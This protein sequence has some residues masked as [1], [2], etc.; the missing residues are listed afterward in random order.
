MKTPAQ[1]VLAELEHELRP[2]ARLLQF[3]AEGRLAIVEMMLRSATIREI[4]AAAVKRG[5]KLSVGTV[6]NLSIR[7]GR[8]RRLYEEHAAMRER[9]LD[10]LQAAGFAAEAVQAVA[11]RALP[12]LTE[13]SAA[14]LGELVFDKITSGKKVD[15]GELQPLVDLF[16]DLLDRA[17]KD[18]EFGLKVQEAQLDREK[19]EL[20]KRKAE[21]AE[22]TEGALKDASLTPEERARRIAEIY[23]RA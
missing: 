22:Q 21:Q 18:K 4:Q 12:Q 6:S 11:T 14:A 3:D 20:L 23:G 10:R 5:V 2:D 16:T 13:S 17:Q 8:L 19:F 7:A 1:A 9:T 15:P